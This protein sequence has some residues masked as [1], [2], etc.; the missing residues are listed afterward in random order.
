V[1]GM[2]GG[3]GTEVCPIKSYYYK[4]DIPFLRELNAGIRS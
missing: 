1:V 4:P 3:K 2:C